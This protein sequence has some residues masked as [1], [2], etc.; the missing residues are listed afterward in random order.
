M[1][2]RLG[3]VADTAV[4]KAVKVGFRTYNRAA[5]EAVIYDSLYEYNIR[6]MN[7]ITRPLVP[8]FQSKVVDEDWKY[9]IVLD[10]C[11]FD[12]FEQTCSI[13]GTLRKAN[14]CSGT[15]RE[16]AVNNFSQGDWSDVMYISAAGWPSMP[17]IWTE[18]MDRDG[19]D[20]HPFYHVEDVWDYGEEEGW[21]KHAVRPEQVRE[22]ATRL[23][24]ENPEK[25][26]IIHFLQ[27][28]TP[29]MGKNVL[30][31]TEFD[32]EGSVY[33]S[34]R[35]KNIDKETVWKAYI[36]NLEYALGEVR[37][38][39]KILDGNVVVTSD[40]GECFGEYNLFEHPSPLV[41]PIIEVP[42]LELTKTREVDP[43][44]IVNEVNHH[45][46]QQ[47][48]ENKEQRREEFLKDLG[49]LE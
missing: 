8:Q 44:E 25:R 5:R 24:A 26:A 16:W 43:S 2:S 48:D 18:D 4:R 14:S 10:A 42:W 23:I 15:T 45:N 39:L 30:S 33:E 9:L 34:M 35:R 46:D 13:D 40:H 1:I 27:P 21:G 31:R 19:V 11:R 36:S 22:A 38:L 37:E 28:H 41:P 7:A 47:D 29:L 32:G 20:D 6:L 49:Y 17:E 12:A 3:S